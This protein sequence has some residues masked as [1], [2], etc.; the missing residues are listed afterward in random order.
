LF[1]GDAAGRLGD[2]PTVGL[3]G[4]V[5]ETGLRVVIVLGIVIVFAGVLGGVEVDFGANGFIGAVPR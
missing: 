4:D 1:E 3:M 5:L 2:A